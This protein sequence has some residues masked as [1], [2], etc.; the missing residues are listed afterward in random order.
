MPGG[1]QDMVLFR[2]EAGG[3]VRA[4]SQLH[5]TRVL[6]IVTTLPAILLYLFDR[7]LTHPIGEPAADM[8]PVELAIM[9]DEF[10]GGVRATPACEIKGVAWD[11]H[12]A[13]FVAGFANQ[14]TIFLPSSAPQEMVDAYVEALRGITTAEGFE[15]QAP[16]VLCACPQ[17]VGEAAMEATKQATSSPPE[18]KQYV[19]DWLNED[20]EITME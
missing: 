17:L 4:L 12:K 8:P 11:A 3:A 7:P 6:I 20:Y 14:N 9:A 13:F 16:E 1:L 19:L 18:A 10:Q 15:T 5:A 2:Q